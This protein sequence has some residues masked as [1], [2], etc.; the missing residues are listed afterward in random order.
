MATVYK[1]EGSKYWQI[2]WFDHNGKRQ[3]KSSRTTD[4]SAAVRIANKFGTDVSLKREG[5]I[6]PR[7]VD[8]SKHMTGAIKGHLDAFATYQRSKSGAEHVDATRLKIEAI[9]TAEGFAVLRDIEPDGVNRYADRLRMEG[10]SLRTIES[11]LQAIKSFTRWAAKT[12]KLP[13]DPLVTVTKPSPEGDRRLTRRFLTHEEFRWLDAVTRVSGESFGMEGIE[14]ALLYSTA[15]QTGLR[16]SELAALT[17]GKL[18]LSTDSPFIVAEARST[19]NKKLAR[20]YVQPELAKEL[21]A[22]VSRKIGGAKVFSMPPNWDVAEMFRADL[23]AARI[24]WLETPQN[25]QKRIEA[26]A[27]DFLRVLDSEGDTLD[28]HALR[29]TTA[30]W[31]IQAGADVRT[32]Q[33]VMRHSDIKLTLQRYGHLFPGSEAAAVARIRDAF[34]NPLPLAATG[35]HGNAGEADCQRNCQHSERETMRIGCE[36]VR[37]SREGEEPKECAIPKANQQETLV[38]E[39]LKE[40]TPGMIRTCDPRIRN[41][42]VGAKNTEKIEDCQRSCQ[43]SVLKALLFELVEIDQETGRVL[44]FPGPLLSFEDARAA[45][46]ELAKAGRLVAIVPTC[47]MGQPMPADNNPVCP[48]NK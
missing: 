12:A 44:P 46:I 26:D 31:L 47:C 48:E 2:A 43:Q 32:V 16:S 3:T 14:R 15:I 11:Y 6:D 10:K 19:K 18:Q 1:R 25:G 40:G 23:A 27:S 35:T 8:M 39:G 17:R 13:S 36:S 7:A 20:Q 28:F 24:A 41:P 4:H 34:S 22:Y 9:C 42:A 37:S 38:F 29:H 45:G 5:V 33:S 21:A 30:T